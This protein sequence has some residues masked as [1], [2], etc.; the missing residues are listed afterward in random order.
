MMQESYICLRAFI[1]GGRKVRFTFYNA[2]GAGRG[3]IELTLDHSQYL[4]LRAPR[5]RKRRIA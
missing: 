3:S 5:H 4:A 2:I 1:G